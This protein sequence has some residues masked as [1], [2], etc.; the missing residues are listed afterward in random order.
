MHPWDT[1]CCTPAARAT[2]HAHRAKP[3][4]HCGHAMSFR[5]FSSTPVRT[6]GEPVV[7]PIIAIA[8]TKIKRVFLG[9]QQEKTKGA[10][11]QAGGI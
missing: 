3:A 10:G 9:P 2:K 7:L 8:V 4:I 11:E 5:S 1:L 6:A